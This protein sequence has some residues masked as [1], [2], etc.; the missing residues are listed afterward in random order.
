MVSR[1]GCL[2]GLL[3]FS[4]FF[5][6]AS[7]MMAV[8]PRGDDWQA[9]EEAIARGLPRTAI[10]RLGPLAA[11]ARRDGAYPE[12]IKAIGLRATLEADLE[13][14]GAVGKVIRMQR[15]ISEAPAEMLPVMET[16]LAGWLWEYFQENRY[17]FL[18]RTAVEVP[19]LGPADPDR[20]AG[21]IPTPLEL[22]RESLETWDLPRVL[23]AIDRQF[24]RALAI[25]DDLREVPAADYEPL[26]VAGT[27]P[28][29]FRPT[30]Y[31]VLAHQ[32]LRFYAADEQAAGGLS[33]PLVIRGDGPIFASTDDFLAW[34]PVVEP[35][36]RSRFARCVSLLQDLI[37]FHRADE[38]PA[39]GLHVELTRL[40]IGRDIA[41][42]EDA[43][44]RFRGALRRF[45]EASSGHPITSLA[46]HELA[47]SLRTDADDVTEAHAAASRGFAAFPDT[48]GGR[49]C[50]NVIREIEAAS[51]SAQAERVWAAPG[52]VIRLRYRNVSRVH[53]RLVP[54]DFEA[55]LRSGDRPFGQP[56]DEQRRRL[57]AQAPARAWSVDLKPTDDFRDRFVSL[58]APL[59]L[60]GG[61]YTLLAGHREDFAEEDNQL[62]VA[63]VWRSDLAIVTRTVPGAVEGLVLAAESGEPLGDAAVEAWRRQRGGGW[64][65][66]PPM[67]TDREGG[68]RIEGGVDANWIVRV[69][70][71][72]QTLVSRPASPARD[73]RGRLASE[74]TRLFT[75]RAIYRPG[76]SIRYKGI[77]YLADPSR[78]RYET[79]AG[80]DVTVELVDV[81]GE[82]VES[83]RHR[84]NPRGSFGGTVT[85][86]RDRLTGRMTLRV[87]EPGGQA[88]ILV[89]EY[90]RPKFRVEFESPE[91]S[92]SLGQVVRIRGQATA[93][94]G[95]PIGGGEVRWRVVREV[96][97]P[98]W[99]HWRSWWLP[100]RPAT[101]EPID[102]GTA[103]TAADGS[104]AV[105][106]PARPDLSVP[107]SAEPTFRFRLVADVTDS[108]G[109]TRSGERSVRIGYVALR[110]SLEA[111]PWQTADEPVD[112]RIR[113]TS[114]DDDG[115]AASGTLR[116]VRLEQPDRVGRPGLG[117]DRG[118]GTP[119]PPGDEPPSPDPTDPHSWADGELVS[120]REVRTDAA[121]N[122]SEKL[123]LPAG[124]YRVRLATRDRAGRPVEAELPLHVIRPD[125][126]R[127]AVR[128]PQ[129]VRVK[130]STV[131]VG[132]TFEAVWGTGHENGRALIEIE[133]RGRLLQRF[134]TDPGKTQVRVTQVVSREM[135]GGFTFRVTSVRDNRAL[136]HSQRIE[137]PWSD[138]EL[139]VRW[140]RFRSKLR[141]G[142]EEV[143]TAVVT[144]AAVASAA[145]ASAVGDRP[146]GSVGPAEGAS[147]SSPA[148]TASPPSAAGEDGPRPL[149]DIEMVATLYD[150]SLEAFV[151][152]RWPD[153]F[154]VF[155]RDDS[156]V[157]S[158]FENGPENL[159]VIAVGWHV[160]RD[161]APLTYRDFPPEI[162][163]PAG[164]PTMTR[165]MLGRA[166]RGGG[167]AM[168]FAA[169]P[170]AAAADGAAEAKAVPDGAEGEGDAGDDRDG[171][172]DPGPEWGG[173]PVRRDLRET[174]FFFPHLLAQEDGT[175]RIEFTMP[176]SLTEWRFQGFAHDRDL[177]G[178]LL[179]DRA[180]TSKD[181]MVQPNP[182][183]FLRE[184]DRLEFTVR[185]ANRSPTRQSG[186]VRLEFTDAIGGES[187]DERLG[188]DPS[189]RGF[190]LASGES[191][192][193]AWPV[194]VPDG[195]GPL[196]YRAIGTSGRLSDGEEGLLPVLPRRLLLRDSL[197]WSIRGPGEEAFRLRGLAESGDTGE[198]RHQSLTL[199]VATNP[200]WYAVLAL[201]TLMDSPR[202]SADE[203]FHRLY[204]H[205]LAHR[206]ATADARIGRVFELWRATPAL[207]SP[208]EKNEAAAGIVLRETP[209]VRQAESESQ[210]RRRI[211]E[212]LDVNRA[213]DERD[214]GLAE[215]VRLQRDDGSWSW[216]PGGRGDDFITA[217][218][219]AGLG[220]LSRLGVPIGSEPAGRG[221]EYLDGRM[222]EVHAAID[223]G[224]RDSSR[225]SPQIALYLYARSFFHRDRPLAAE[226]RD[227]F[228]YWSE[229]A[230]RDWPRL[231]TPQSQALLAVALHRFGEADAAGEILRSL[232]ERSRFDPR[233]GRHWA[234]SRRPTWD[235]A[236]VPTQA[237]MI[238]AFDEVAGDT[239]TVDECRD[240]LLAQKR[241]QDWTGSR[242]TADAVYALLLR[243]TD[244]L[245]GG[246]DTEVT[247]G[248]Q[249]VPAVESEPGTGFFERRWG[250]DEIRP[251]LAEV[252]VRKPDRGTAWGGLHW[253][254]F[255]DLAQA[256]ATREGELRVAKRLFV[257]RDSPAGPRLFPVDGP[258]RVGE[259]LVSRLEVRADRDFEYV[260]LRE[261]RGS[262]TEPV[263][264]RSEYRFAEG[265][266]FYE[267]TRD[268][269]TDFFFDRLPAGTYVFETS[270]R[271]QHRGEYPTGPAEI[272]CVYA[273]EFGG[274]SE[275]VALRVE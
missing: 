185:V 56:D 128:L 71:R 237:L 162:L 143:W 270:A 207:D 30:V 1:T 190:D 199:Q 173:V 43:A 264:V 38:E 14:E 137:V 252:Q 40:T 250:A 108:S 45:A 65:E 49:R 154:G 214:R 211:G 81:N 266:A 134:W 69:T 18:R 64:V 210:S 198:I 212:S 213:R 205:A 73:T 218:I 98:D 95:V 53:F 243:G 103:V 105:E 12:A 100:P 77:S 225:L 170:M 75:D 28:D 109:E 254:Y 164:G 169:V 94:T 102:R 242:A 176:E 16:I 8:G 152:H 204:A 215:L 236:S 6:G 4:L 196:A 66:L 209:W 172:K 216:F 201:P 24:T 156:V 79:I 106:F 60:P 55:F 80:R 48:I 245:G 146:G 234:D 110:A 233:V 224:D 232:K 7:E 62:S 33:D 19:P 118:W 271:V 189:V 197:A 240:W 260:H 249:P 194:R 92:P 61:G 59:D 83:V 68:F 193:L 188:I 262:G 111:E 257:K 168:A 244:L 57:L 268:T 93:Y 195:I 78:D 165:R 11:Q 76:Q 187:A 117:S 32:A 104:F 178:G 2:A 247:V 120:E 147:S 139:A 37:R 141:P 222:A 238:E 52:A 74:Q 206:I 202:P 121:G 89:E 241:T 54:L 125:A 21:R 259:A 47:E 96:R 51:A 132:D 90:R 116:V 31:D 42:G 91:S 22:R 274:R 208:L 99:W 135:R 253:Q 46:W 235:A 182:P 273:P 13:G 82:V 50:H 136:L 113:T 41:V 86:P 87:R 160:G 248:G 171:V 220:R 107:E 153:G 10:E 267:S 36:R 27:A 112:L 115:Q 231:A 269:A 5:G 101:A 181:L 174:A 217:S 34:Q 44:G 203:A 29:T 200:S 126:D 17:R 166:M 72:D 272:R 177:R 142:A 161:P 246:R 26:L 163:S 179:V 63:T 158:R 131:E 23:A 226:H 70:H 88:S 275:S 184:G 155:R 230:K 255:G 138:R 219:T 144:P 261:R 149:P 127:L 239:R 145:V 119:Q 3:G 15:E 67:R 157:R 263:A 167:E 20:E 191:V 25:A 123:L 223:P 129:L 130:A 227:A 35:G 114:L 39:A 97:F 180:V 175:V 186:G 251:S 85:A 84:T 258:L 228:R 229:Q 183:R 148:S 124:I 151:R 122:A 256:A 221:L 58:D 192:S 9:V 140:E 265:L 150:A 133:H 159:Q